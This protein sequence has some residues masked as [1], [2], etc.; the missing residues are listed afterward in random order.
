MK[1]LAS[2]RRRNTNYNVF[3]NANT[4]E[5]RTFLN[6]ILDEL[7]DLL[8]LFRSDSCAFLRNKITVAVLVKVLILTIIL[9]SLFFVQ[10]YDENTRKDRY[11]SNATS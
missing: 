3:G 8:H 10:T 6:S 9:V 7:K 4:T 2:L 1:F 5:H 11:L